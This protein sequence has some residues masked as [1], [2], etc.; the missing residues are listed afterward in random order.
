MNSRHNSKGNFPKNSV[1]WGL[2]EFLFGYFTDGN[3]LLDCTTED[4]ISVCKSFC[5]HTSLSMNV[6]HLFRMSLRIPAGIH[7]FTIPKKLKEFISKLIAVSKTIVL[8]L[9]N[10]ESHGVIDYL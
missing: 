3:T 4:Y 8:D 9:L 5:F 6:K 7:Q 1:G 2:P 10:F